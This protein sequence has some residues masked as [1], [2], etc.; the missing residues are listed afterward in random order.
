MP[1]GIV[2]R[3][4]YLRGSSILHRCDARIKIALLISFLLTA[5]FLPIGAWVVYA[6]MGGLLLV[7][8][9]ASELPVSVLLQRALVLE[10]PILLVLLPQL[11]L[12]KGNFVV[13]TVIK[14]FQISFSMSSLVRITSLLIR[15]YLSLGFA[16]LITAVT[17]FEDL[18]A[19]MRACGL[20]RMLA[21]I[22]A[23]MW[24][25]LFVLIEE[26]E[27]MTQARASRSAV[28]VNSGMRAG[29]SFGWR[30]QVTGGMAGALLLRTLERSE[31]IYQAM[32]ARGYDGEVRLG[33]ASEPL[34]WGQKAAMLLMLLMGAAL[35]L[36]A[37]GMNGA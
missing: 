36:I 28:P 2:Q 25:Y 31:R 5:A 34:T 23:L 24:R 20:P 35:V 19:A 13:L 16:V 22:F 1:T 37:N 18:L 32:L 21:S 6:L 26:M 9:L 11:F 15:S 30:A 10:I 33:H 12:Q 3:A 29:G 27:R 17:R 4:S 7:A 14:G 8:M